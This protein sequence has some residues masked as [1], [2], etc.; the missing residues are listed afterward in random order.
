MVAA[1]YTL[2][3]GGVLAYDCFKKPVKGFGPGQWRRW[4]ER[5]KEISKQE[6]SKTRLA[7]AT[8]EAHKFMVP[9]YPETFFSF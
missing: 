3:A 5:F 7:S 1:Q 9:L 2:L 6:G 8:E 4:A